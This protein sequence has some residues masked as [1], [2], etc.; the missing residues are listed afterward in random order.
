MA[1]NDTIKNPNKKV[2]ADN[3]EK[4]EDE[5]EPGNLQMAWEVLELAKNAFV[6]MAEKVGGNDK[7]NAD[8][9]VAEA[10]LLLGEVSL[11]N[12]NYTQAVEDLAGCLKIRESSLPPDSRFVWI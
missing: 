1:K 11:E 10:F 5:E 2:L 6:K 3:S 8:L 12:E 4:T 9:K 7:K